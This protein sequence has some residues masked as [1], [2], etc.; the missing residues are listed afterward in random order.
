MGSSEFNLRQSSKVLS[1]VLINILKSIDLYVFTL[2]SS[3]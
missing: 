1:R 2:D 3:D